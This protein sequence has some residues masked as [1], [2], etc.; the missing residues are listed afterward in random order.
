MKIFNWHFTS[1]KSAKTN[2]LKQ[3]EDNKESRGLPSNAPFCLAPHTGMYFN[4]DGT[5]G[6]CCYNR[7]DIFG[8]YPKQ[9]IDDIWKSMTRT[10]LCAD[11]SN[12]HL[13][14]GCNRCHNQFV[15]GNIGGMLATRY[16]YMWEY[17]LTNT[18]KDGDLSLLSPKTMEFEIGSV[19]NLECTMCSG[20]CSSAIRQNRDKLPPLISP[21]D[22]AFVD[23]LK[24]YI[25]HLIDAKFLG[26]EPF[27]NPLNFKIWDL[28]IE[29]HSKA[30]IAITTNGS[31]L[32][33]RVKETLG[34]LQN[35][36]LTISIDSLNQKN[37]ESIRKNAK[38]KSV[39]QNIEWLIKNKYLHALAV[40]PM[41]NNWADMPE[42]VA[43]CNK[44]DLSIYFN[45]VFNP[46]EL[47]IRSLSK[48]DIQKITYFL[49][50]QKIDLEKNVPDRKSR[51]NI[52]RYEG[53]I[54]QCKG[55]LNNKMVINA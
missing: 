31:I 36:Y 11:L 55:W 42:M 43:Y 9:T 41:V 8:K 20:Y 12:N 28:F 39:I 54:E 6:A 25:P 33:E 7:K 37:Y 32:N 4:Q 19:C 50:S 30:V 38:F 24:P 35:L 29:C 18:Q 14:S 51:E 46:I 44:H 5:V 26:G 3:Y 49:S 23:Q 10:H 53:L 45:T 2:T 34:S 48:A 40:C 13:R 52:D 21:Y 27:L 16:D 22:E 15:S 47:S 17:H 1:S